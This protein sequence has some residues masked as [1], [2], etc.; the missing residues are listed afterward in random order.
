M[1]KKIEK[2][3]IWGF[4]S[5]FLLTMVWKPLYTASL[6]LA[7]NLNSVTAVK[8]LTSL[9]GDMDRD[10]SI[11]LADVWFNSPLQVACING[12][13]EIVEILLKKG[14]NIN[15]KGWKPLTLA[16]TNK[17][18]NTYEMVKLLIEYGASMDNMQ[19]PPIESLLIGK[20]D[21]GWGGMTF[22]KK[23]NLTEEEMYEV[24]LLLVENGASLTHGKGMISEEERTYSIVHCTA[25]QGNVMILKYMVEE[26]GVDLDRKIFGGNTALM[27]ATDCE[28]V[29][30]VEYLISQGVD[31]TI[32]DDEGE[33]A[34]DIA[35]EKGNKEIIALL[36]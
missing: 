25:V 7:I 16:L 28:N 33:I 11:R 22:G 26:V 34:L 18:S 17:E 4:L 14:A 32:T 30:M 35:K 8:I 24:F 36:Q 2:I 9:P 15:T 31:I 3:I 10:N 20:Y 1:D 12:N 23:D 13:V 6:N 19:E 21:Y 29:N 5:A 27:I